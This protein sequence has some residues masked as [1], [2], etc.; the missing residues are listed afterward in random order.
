MILKK[1][2]LSIV[3]VFLIGP[4]FT[5]A[6]L[7]SNKYIID[8]DTNNSIENTLKVIDSIDNDRGIVVLSDMIY[9]LKL[10]TKVYDQGKKVTNRYAL[11]KGQ[12]VKIESS[13]KGSKRYVDTISILGK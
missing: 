9:R 3:L 5:F 6:Q 4:S 1:F 2:A 10:N 12:R 7:D 13:V 11:K 8:L